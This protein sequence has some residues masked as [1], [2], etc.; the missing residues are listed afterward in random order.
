LEFKELGALSLKNI[1]HPVEAFAVRSGPDEESTQSAD[2]SPYTAAGFPALPDKP[3]I[4]VLPFTN[5]SGDV[6]QEY[7]SDGIT[8]DVITELSRNR[9]FFVIARN[10]SFSYRS[11]SVDTD[12]T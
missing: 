7:F 5:M 4:A 10:S 8:E 1:A 2:S 3:S 12:W 11:R 6:E 9:G